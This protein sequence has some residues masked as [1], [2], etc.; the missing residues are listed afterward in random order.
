MLLVEDD[1][2][3]IDH[4]DFEDLPPVLAILD[5][6]FCLELVARGHEDIVASAFIACGPEGVV[7][8]GESD[9]DLA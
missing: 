5:V 8:V 4:Q 3:E 2:A 9:S 6:E 7:S 1:L